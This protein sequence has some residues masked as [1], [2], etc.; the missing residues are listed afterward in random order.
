[1]PFSDELLLEAG[2]LAI[3]VAPLLP[4]RRK[5]SKGTP[6]DL[7]SF[8]VVRWLLFRFLVTCGLSKLISGDPKWW[9]LSG[10]NIRFRTKYIMNNYRKSFSALGYHFET[11]PLPSP[12]SW[13]A[14]HIPQQFLKLVMVFVNV[15]EIAMPFLFFAPLRGLRQICFCFQV[16]LC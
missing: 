15:S 4:G 12:L 7:I 1:M 9:N 6:S 16:N 8:W 5:G 11:M 2:F 14:Y 3:L 10:K 13:Y